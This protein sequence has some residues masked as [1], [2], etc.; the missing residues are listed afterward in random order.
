MLLSQDDWH[1]GVNLSDQLVRIAGNNRASPQP[2]VGSRIFPPFP[3]SGKSEWPIILHS[4]REWNL[5]AA[6]RAPFVKAISRNKA[7]TFFERFAVR[8]RGVDRFSSG[9][10][11]LVG[12][13]RIF[14]P[15]RD[16]SPAGLRS[17]WEKRLSDVAPRALGALS[18]SSK[19]T[20][21]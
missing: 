11:C 15:V 3:Q 9:I 21:F 19:R 1:S 5:S 20:R 16:Q 8:R 7:P 12:D 2:L 14:C 13:L 6:N 17:S 18:S 4:D 10:D